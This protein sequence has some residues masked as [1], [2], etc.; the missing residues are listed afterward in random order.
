MFVIT[1]NVYFASTRKGI[2]E[3]LCGIYKPAPKR[4]WIPP[5]FISKFK[6]P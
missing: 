4:I 3:E 6:S 2:I 1:G 5:F